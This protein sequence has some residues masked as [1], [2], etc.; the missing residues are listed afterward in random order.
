MSWTQK[1][2]EELYQEINRRLAEDPE[3]AEK[4]RKDPGKTLEELAGQ[5]LP[6]GFS[7]QLVEKDDNY[8]QTY[9]L[10]DFAG[11]EIAFSDLDDVAG[12][13]GLHYAGPGCHLKQHH[14]KISV[15][16]FVSACAAAVS[17]TACPADACGAAAC[18]ADA[19]C[20]AKACGGKAC[21]AEA[22]CGGK[23]CGGQACGAEAAC[24]AKGCGSQGCAGATGCS[25]EACSLDGCAAYGGCAAKACAVEGCGSHG[26]CMDHVC[27]GDA[28]GAHGGCLGKACGG[29]A[30]GGYL[31]CAAKGCGGDACAAFVGC[32]AEGHIKEFC[33]AHAVHEHEHEE[34]LPPMGE[35]AMADFLFG[36]GMFDASDPSPDGG[37]P[38]AGGDD[39]Q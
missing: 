33:A 27:G 5:P 19:G 9:V 16:L 20:G 11:E 21:G 38:F 1:K 2:L 39:S 23:A 34:E 37:D 32:L 15:A 35:A 18:P 22:A 30:C 25:A 7:L 13:K 29:E 24:G 6:E 4:L 36:D 14:E 8:G 17:I 10:P 3:F 31:G 28:C 26:G 12:G